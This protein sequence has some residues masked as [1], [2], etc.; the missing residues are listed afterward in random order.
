MKTLTAILFLFIVTKQVSAQNTIES[1]LKLKDILRIG[2]GKNDTLSFN[3]RGYTLLLPGNTSEIR[4]VIISLE[5]RKF[6][7]NDNP[8]QQIYLRAISKGFAVLY[9]STGIPLDLFFSDK[10][11][12]YIDLLLKNLFV[13]YKIPNKNIFFLGVNLAG[14]RALKYI[15]FCRKGKSK[16]NPDVKGIVLCDGV[17]DWAREWFEAK[18][19][20]RD[21]FA[22]SSVAE[23]KLIVY[24]LEKN[25]GGT[26]KNQLEKYLTFSLY[27]YFDESHRHIKYFKDLA[28]RAYTEPATHYWMET[29]RKTPFETNF[30]D[31]VGFVN[32][33]KLAGNTRSELF[34]FNEDINNKDRRN[35]DYTWS[36]VDKTELVNWMEE[37]S[38]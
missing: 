11:F 32:E 16:F 30:P 18:K 10:S 5:D 34:V 26:P 3:D 12:L 1:Y 4:G 9:L 14:H 19:G 7:L 31:M 38:K 23:G 2:A 24:L 22:E 28:V 6:N 33:L 15:E 36:L 13:Q 29:K 25:L 37:Q 21:N 8:S 35:P 17:L 20:I 27:S